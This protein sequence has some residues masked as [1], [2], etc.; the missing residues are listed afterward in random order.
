LPREEPIPTL[1]AHF[2][3]AS[4]RKLGLKLPRFTPGQIVKLQS[5]DWPGNVR[6]LHNVLQHAAKQKWSSGNVE[7]FW[8]SCKYS[9]GK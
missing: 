7:M 2:L 8:L 5:Y 1:A 4:A 6:E 3:A 9:S